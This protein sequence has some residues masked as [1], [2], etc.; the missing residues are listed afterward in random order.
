MYFMYVH[1]GN[2][3]VLLFNIKKRYASPY[4]FL[5]GDKEMLNFLSFYVYLDIE[6]AKYINVKS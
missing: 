5:Y 6:T 4:S 3:C 1:V 2:D